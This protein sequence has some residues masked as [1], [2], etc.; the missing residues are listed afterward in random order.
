MDQRAQATNLTELREA[1]LMR[2]FNGDLV[3]EEDLGLFPCSE[4]QF[5]SLIPAL[6]AAEPSFQQAK[7]AGGLGNH[8]DLQLVCGAGTKGLELK[9]SSRNLTSAVL[10]WQ[11]WEGG[12]QFLQGQIVSKSMAS[13][14]GPCGSPM[15]VAWF[16]KVKTLMT[17]HL[18]TFAIPTYEDYKKVLFTLGSEKKLTTPAAK[19]IQELRAKEELQKLF[20]AAWLLFEDEWF[21]SHTPVFDAFHELL[22]QVLGEKDYWVNI[23][24]GGASLIEGFNVVGL[25][26][27]GTAKKPEG[28]TVFRYKIQL[29][30]KKRGDMKEV[31]IV[32]KFYWKNGGQGVQNINLLVVSDPFA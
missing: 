28:G 16:E 30:K 10:E 20:Q 6:R 21:A 11:P 26:Y 3:T 29:Q 7:K 5:A 9:V 31:P 14:L 15:V 22:K 19:L 27:V 17:T 23:N 24:K 4:E 8:K 2:H 18:P 1:A 12:V 32:V 25:S 13:F